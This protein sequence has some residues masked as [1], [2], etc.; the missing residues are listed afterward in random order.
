MFCL[1]RSH[2]RNNNYKGA[3]KEVCLSPSC[4]RDTT[5]I[6]VAIMYGAIATN[7][8]FVAV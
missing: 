4:K 7:I 3:F 1:L 2:F 5:G 8:N 6:F